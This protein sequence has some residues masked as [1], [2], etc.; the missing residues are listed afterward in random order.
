MI[1]TVIPLTVATPYPA[2]SSPEPSLGSTSSSKSDNP[3][4]PSDPADPDTTSPLSLD[5]SI[6]VKPLSISVAVS[7]YLLA[8]S[9]SPRVLVL[10]MKASESPAAPKEVVLPSI[11]SPLSMECSHTEYPFSDPVIVP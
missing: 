3:G 11:T 6:T 7:P 2:A 4:P 1:E 10:I 5:R 8:H 9:K